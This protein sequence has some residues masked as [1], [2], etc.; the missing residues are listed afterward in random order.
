MMSPGAAAIRGVLF[1]FHGTLVDHRDSGAWIEA[2]VQLMGSAPGRCGGVGPQLV[3]AAREHLD[4][5]WGHA[6]TIDPG[7]SR[8]L[9]Q[10]RHREVFIQAVSLCPAIEQGLAEALYA[11]MA[12]QWVAFDDTI[13][14]LTELVERGIPSVVVSNIGRD[15][16]PFLSR[17]G[18]ADKVDGVVLSYE[19]GAVK[20]QPEIFALALGLLGI[21]AADA[22]MVGDSWRDDS[23]AA[24]LGIRTLILPQTSGPRHGLEAVLRLIG[25]P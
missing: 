25:A 5:I 15:I 23:G 18:L 17:A 22:L 21:P 8:D 9:S 7:S 16:R 14:V 6:R 10:D 3:P 1:D 13:P 11:V 19:V 12:E 4:Q 24:A 2:A 20:P